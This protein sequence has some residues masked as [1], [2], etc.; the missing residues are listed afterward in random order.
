MINS[1]EIFSGNRATAYVNRPSWTDD[2]VRQ[3]LDRCDLSSD[4]TIADVGSG[5]GK[6]SRAL[7]TAMPCSMIYGVEPNED[8]RKLA[9]QGLSEFGDRFISV[10]GSALNTN[11]DNRIQVDLITA[12]QAAHWWRTKEN[13][14]DVLSEFRRVSKEGAKIAYAFYNLG[15]GERVSNIGNDKKT[16]T[17]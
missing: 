12:G 13:Q 5:D 3:L 15:F 17:V 2:Y 10:D 4:C 14:E 11:L 9:E 1:T 7:L 6:F 8:M 16:T